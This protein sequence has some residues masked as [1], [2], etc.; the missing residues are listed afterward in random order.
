MQS[1]IFKKR[2]IL[3]PDY[4][5][6]ELPH[7]Q[8][9]QVR[10]ASILASALKGS[11]PSNIFIYGHVG[12]GKTAVSKFVLKRLKE[13]GDRH[14]LTFDFVYINCRYSDTNYR[15]LA[16]IGE[17]VGLSIPFTGLSS[18]EVFRR[19]TKALSK[20]D[21]L[22]FIVLD[23][24]DSLVKKSG[25]EVL[26]RLVRANGESQGCRI[27]IIGITNDLR[28]IESL[29]ARIRSSLGE[30]E[31]VFPPYNAEQL[32]DILQHRARDAFNPQ[33]LTNGVIELCSALAAKEHGDARR[34]L[35]LL[36]IAGEIAER[37]S[38]MGVTEEYV[39]RAYREIERDKVTEVIKTLPIHAKMVL[40]SVYLNIQGNSEG[41]TTGD[42]YETYNRLCPQ[43]GLDSLTQRRLCDFINEMD[44]L[45]ILN[46]RLVSKG[47][48]GRTK[49]VRIAAGERILKEA[50]QEDKRLLPFIPL[51]LA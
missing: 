9:Q 17:H 48:Y 35:E 37:E 19:F 21:G 36:R 25:D 40:L 45:G 42:V 28:L 18:A 23:E 5:P 46:A 34:A 26:Y 12:T 4:V 3:R 50:L 41:P 24:V 33:A 13:E 14:G 49:I 20:R 16:D 31:I 6:E 11:R 39:R 51:T 43:V 15:V 8:L 7:R 1:A 38:S 10:L 27:A 47:R 2:D 22:L 30:E 32:T 29:D 44:M